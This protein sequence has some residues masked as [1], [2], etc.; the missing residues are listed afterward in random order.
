MRTISN[1]FKQE[2]CKKTRNGSSEMW[3]IIIGA[4]IAM[5]VLV[6]LIIWFKSGG[7][8]G[9]GVIN[10]NIEGSN[11]CDKDRVVDL[12]DRCVC[13]A[14]DENGKVEGCPEETAAT[15]FAPD[16]KTAKPE[17]CVE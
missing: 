6:L 14:G 11:D 4:T 16:G 7:D 3:W 2:K 17:C 10:E 9:F 1:Y 5:V 13:I 8:K 15:K 12:F